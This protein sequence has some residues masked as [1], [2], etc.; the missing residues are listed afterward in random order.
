MSVRRHR[1]RRRAGSPEHCSPSSSPT[2]VK[3][4][5]TRAGRSG[6]ARQGHAALRA[7]PRSARTSRGSSYAT[8]SGRRRTTRAA[9]TRRPGGAG[10]RRRRN[11]TGR[12]SPAD[13]ELASPH[14]VPA[15]PDRPRLLVVR[16]RRATRRG[17]P[18]RRGRR[19]AARPR[20]ISPAASSW[21]GAGSPRCCSPPRS[22]P[23]YVLIWPAAGCCSPTA[24]SWAEGRYLAV[25]LDTALRAQRRHA[26]AASWRRSPRCSAR[27]SLRPGRGRH[28]AAGRRWST[29][30][31]S[32]PSASPGTCATASASPSRSSP[33]RCST[34]AQAARPAVDAD[35]PGAADLTRESLRYLYRILFLLYA[36][37]RPEL[38]VLPVD[39]PEYVEGYGLARLREL[40]LADADQRRRAE[41]GTHLYES[42][43]LLFRLVNDGPPAR[44]TGPD[45]DA[46]DGR[47][48]GG[49]LRFEPLRADLFPPE[50]DRA[51][52]R[53]SASANGCAAAGAAHAAAHQGA[54][55]P[56]PRLHLVRRSSASTS[57]AR[58]T[59]G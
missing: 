37:A 21:H 26:P 39:A 5:R 24:A 32:T 16:A 36:E 54:A 2:T 6:G 22:R 46:D 38:G 49:G 28:R 45:G 34:P 3:A 48:D 27:D 35:G 29:S 56:R 47:D 42:L 52:R 17:P 59:R 53:R 40:V 19:A 43:A 31:S 18:R 33:T 57:S 50:R 41:R 12:P 58:C 8:A 9:T 14:V 23:R 10:L 15:A 13:H 7:S 1:R 55:G 51:D 30:R 11:G 25:D 44:D 20:P 4:L